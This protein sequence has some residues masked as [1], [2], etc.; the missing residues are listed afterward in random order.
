[1]NDTLFIFAIELFR[2]LIEQEENIAIGQK[3]RSVGG[4]EPPKKRRCLE[5]KLLDSLECTQLFGLTG[6]DLNP[7]SLT[8]KCT[9]ASPTSLTGW[10]LT[11][12]DQ[13]HFF[14]FPDL[15]LKPGND[16]GNCNPSFK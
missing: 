7:P 1:M 4:S 13:T 9:A 2:S 10:R 8:L 11:N 12:S 14:L 16:V 5:K 6:I 3:R 15:E